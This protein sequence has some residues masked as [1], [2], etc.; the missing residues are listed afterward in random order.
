MQEWN[1]DVKEEDWKKKSED[2][3]RTEIERN[4]S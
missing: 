3:E 1:S 2:E 4:G